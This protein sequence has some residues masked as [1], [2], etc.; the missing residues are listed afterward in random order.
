[1]TEKIKKKIGFVKPTGI[2][3]KKFFGFEIPFNK[4]KDNKIDSKTG[5]LTF[6]NIS[7]Y[8]MYVEYRKKEGF[9]DLP[10]LGR[11]EYTSFITSYLN[12]V[13]EKVVFEGFVF[14]LPYFLGRI[15][16]RKSNRA[17]FINKT[18]EKEN[19]N[20]TL[21][22]HTF[23][24]FLSLKWD[25]ELAWFKNRTVWR[26]KMGS[27]AKKCVKKS[28]KDYDKPLTNGIIA[29]GHNETKHT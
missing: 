1:M 15:Y 2:T 17:G 16:Y 9:K 14:I 18:Y 29:H 6:S 5:K 23:R 7:F 26:F 19:K 12:K 28:I 24:K 10:E 21:N 3:D 4:T 13:A 25:K 27:H 20:R 22:L 8:N 11:K